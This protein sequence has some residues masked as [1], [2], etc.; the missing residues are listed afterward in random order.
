MAHPWEK[1]LYKPLNMVNIQGYPNTMPKEINKWLPKFPGNNVITVEDHIYTMGRDMDNAGIEHE[2]VAMRLFASSLTE[3]S[4]D[5][6]RALPDNHIT[7][8][9]AFAKLFK[10]R[11]STKEDG[12]TLGAQFNQI[13]KREYETVKE[14]ITRFDKLYN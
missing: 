9:E 7:S 4:L 3:E 11:W 13:K 10:D 5:W 12:G 14:F 6:F 8:Y 1:D 2:D